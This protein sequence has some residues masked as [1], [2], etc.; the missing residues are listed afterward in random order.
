MFFAL[1]L[2]DFNAHIEEFSQGVLVDNLH[3]HS[4]LYADDLVLI[5][6]DRKVL[7]FQLNTL[8]NFSKI[9]KMEVNMDKKKVMVL[10]LF[11]DAFIVN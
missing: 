6:S 11:Q 8:D 9:L 10:T 5:S 3:I 4:L 2:N 1:F 7:Q